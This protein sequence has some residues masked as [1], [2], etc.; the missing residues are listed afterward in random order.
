MKVLL[1]DDDANFALIVE[2]MLRSSDHETISFTWANGLE[3]GIQQ[4][5]LDPVNVILLDLSPP[6]SDGLVTLTALK[7]KTGTT[8][9]IVLTGCNDEKLAIEAMR[10]GAQDYLLKTD[11]DKR[12]FIRA[13]RYAIERGNA[14]Q[15][16]RELVQSIDA[17]VWAADPVTWR[18]TFVS[19]AAEKILGYPIERWLQESDF[20][21]NLIHPD[22]RSRAV[23]YCQ[24]QVEKGDN[25]E[26]EYRVVAVDGR[27]VWLRD[28]VRVIKNEFGKPI[29]LRGVMIDITQ[30]KDAAAELQKHHYEIKSL[31]EISQV[32][33]EAVE[34]DTGI[35][36]ALE[37]SIAACGF[38]FGD[39][40][41]TTPDGE[42]VSVVA[43]CGFSDPANLQRNRRP[44]SSTH[45][46]EQ[47]QQSLVM[48]NI[49]SADRFRSLKLE[50]A[51][52]AVFVPLRAGSQSLGFLQ[53]ASR[54]AKEIR[55]NELALAEAMGRQI[56]IAIQKAKLTEM[57]RTNLRRIQAMYESNLAV[58]STLDLRAV[59]DILL[60]KMDIFPSPGVA[61]TI[62][63]LDGET[64]CFEYFANHN[65][66]EE[67]WTQEYG[68]QRPI[69][70][71]GLARLALE[72]LA[73]LE[74]S[75]LQSDPR[76]R[77]SA[78]MRKQGLVSYL[79][80][81]LR[82]K[83]K[84]VGVIGIYTPI[85][86]R[87]TAEEIGYI[88][89]L[90][91]QAAI[92]IHNARLYTEV[93]KK[94]KELAALFDV[95]SSASQS[96]DMQ[97]ILGEVAQKITQIFDFDAT[98]ILLF[99]R[100]KD[101]LHL[102]ASYKT[103]EDFFAGPSIY[104]KGQGISGT[105]AATGEAIVIENIE[106]DSRYE[107]LTHARTALTN[108]QKFCAS[109]PVKYKEETLGV[110]TCFGRQP[111]RLASHEFQLITSMSSQVA[112]AVENAR[113]YEETKRSFER[114]HALHEI[115]LAV[116]STLD[117]RTILDLLLEKIEHFLPYAAASVLRVLN[118]ETGAFDAT[119]YRNLDE[120]RQGGGGLSR[121][122]MEQK[123]PLMIVNGLKDPRLRYPEF[124]RRHGFVS[125]LAVPLIDKGEVLGY[126]AIFT[127]EERIFA[128]EDVEFL[129]S[130]AAQA[131]IAIDNAKS[132]EEA[133]GATE[134]AT[135]LREINLAITSSLDIQTQIDVLL[136]KISQIFP[137]YVLTVRILNKETGEFEVLA[138]RKLDERDWKNT[139]PK[140]GIGGLNE[141]VQSRKV[142]KIT[143]VQ[144]DPRIYFHDFM[145][146][147]GLV[148]FLGVP[149]NFQEE[150]L[151][152]LGFFTR[153]R[154]DF[155]DSEVEFM[156]TLAE[157]V[158]IAVHNSQLY[159]Q[160][161]RNTQELAALH[162]VASAASQ[163]LDLPAVLRAALQEITQIFTFDATAAYLLNDTHDEL[164]VRAAF[165]DPPDWF[166]GAGTTSFKLGQ[167]IA[168]TVA[169]TGEAIVIGDILNDPA[170]ERLSLT[171]RTRQDG[172]RF[173]AGF[174]INYKGETVGV[175][176]CVGQQPRQLAKDEVQLIA[177]MCNQ[178]AV[179]IENARL[180]EQTQKQTEQLRNLATHLE[181]VREQERSRISREIHDEIGQTLAA[182][183]FDA[184]WIKGKLSIHQ[185]ALAD[186]LAEMSTMIDNTIQAIRK[187][188]ARLR[189]D[190]LDKL[191]LA[192]AIEWQLQD[193]RK[194]TGIQYHFAADPIDSRL[195]ERQATT[196]FRIFQESLANVA[197]HSHATRVNIDLEQQDAQ[198][199]L[200][201][202]DDG[203]GIEG[204]KVF[205]TQSLGLLG[206]RERAAALGGNVTVE[207]NHSR[208][209][210][211]TA[212][213][214]I[215]HRD[216]AREFS[217][218][219]EQP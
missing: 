127:K 168:G 92:A 121:I 105:V 202:D 158:A 89:S 176:M 45:R 149:L 134:R 207:R 185:P 86:Y 128:R 203:D 135:V 118:K 83:D 57:L 20:W 169:M 139:T 166:A 130:F 211:M 1:I 187:I 58:T 60:E 165:D 63:L 143:D 217:P 196:L 53:L 142:A 40:L 49:Q 33:L 94:S 17:I 186:R 44:E 111:R 180:Y 162:A 148:S 210:T 51:E 114:I 21:V 112:V 85:P 15:K 55:P 30:S 42:F 151:G 104:L 69:S 2:A 205:D 38:D 29:I 66:N 67:V 215:D 189:P 13:I 98:R 183:K 82:I 54:R 34:P 124:W 132:Y 153:E 77:H 102:R 140:V 48:H 91:S 84:P 50:G 133:K 39:I 47:L 123:V 119:A 31:Q 106:T 73:P 41:L 72:S 56:G 80:V 62:Q 107:R 204:D 141:V 201:V 129:S 90:A 3:K 8:P 5:Q 131:A 109:F 120:L 192:A 71:S 4:L 95:T 179:A 46:R 101:E 25:H 103:H 74:V 14:E 68:R 61:I 174:P 22:D 208:G 75:D 125:Y 35:Q 28:I 191:G 152:V 144:H 193:F 157:Q 171:K 195:N 160:A 200:R 181:T 117:L 155:S 93:E 116:T 212:Y 163:S 154:H 178:A 159:E 26:F 19:K 110:I 175:I 164:H 64:G 188:A 173:I 199:F 70:E 177:S 36:K 18:F 198:V 24:R 170:Y 65:L 197:R 167:G 122:A 146:R 213:L 219:S 32:I 96:L 27:V 7:T 37:K 100:R 145:R 115:N 6:Y 78:F 99:D 214:P 206:M 218:R 150:I 108:G 137:A 16:Y 194:R 79:G 182:L 9:I 23:E 59:L 209:T 52:T 88:T 81:P 184:T 11:I 216:Q 97:H 113:L 76:V 156:T 136:N 87:F 147:N 172:R 10:L 126:I 190:I 138:C 161:K 43:D 12:A